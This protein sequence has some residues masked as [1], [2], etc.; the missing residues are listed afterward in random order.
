VGVMCGGHLHI[1]REGIIIIITQ[2][3]C[4]MESKDYDRHSEIITI[5]P[6]H[7]ALR[8]DNRL[9]IWEQSRVTHVHPT[10]LA[11]AGL[12]HSWNVLPLLL[13][14]ENLRARIKSLSRDS[15]RHIKCQNTHTT[16]G[17]GLKSP[18]RKCCFKPFYS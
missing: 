1:H 7:V 13:T 3:Y 17:A 16:R 10:F 4:P 14:K 8:C 12:S 6:A 2:V 18:A 9:P 5:L 11:G 15:V